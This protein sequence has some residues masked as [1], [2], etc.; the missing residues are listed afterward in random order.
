MHQMQIVDFT[1]GRP[2]VRPGRKYVAEG[3][4]RSRWVRALGL[5]DQ[6][7]EWFK[8]PEAPSWMTAE[9]YAALPGSL[10]VRECAT[11]P[12]CRGSAPAW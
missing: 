4:P 1:P 6:V 10:L 5:T 3:R 12:R 2:H 7:V 8:P 11:G 9:Q